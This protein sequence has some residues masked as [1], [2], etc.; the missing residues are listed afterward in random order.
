MKFTAD[1][2]ELKSLIKRMEAL[3]GTRVEAGFF[4][5]DR[6]GA[7]ND[8]LQ[9]AQVAYWNDR[10]IGV[11]RREFMAP[12]FLN[13]ENYNW[14][15][16]FITQAVQAAI[17]GKPVQPIL[18]RLGEEMK[19]VIQVNIEDYP[20]SNSRAWVAI[21]GFDDP[22]LYTGKMLSSVKYKIRK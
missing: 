6:Y 18:K 13:A 11:P 9:V 1:Y 17:H 22:L 8:F 5:E 14:Y 15:A 20:G 16:N 19:G 4:A 21:K 3:D 12:S 10:G 7:E 2:R